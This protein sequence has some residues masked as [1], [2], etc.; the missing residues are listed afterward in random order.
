MLP[1][2]YHFIY[3]ESVAKMKSRS[4]SNIIGGIAL[5]GMYLANLP[6]CAPMPNAPPPIEIIR[7][8]Q[9]RIF[10]VNGFTYTLQLQRVYRTPEGYSAADVLANGRLEQIVDGRRFRL[11]GG[12]FHPDSQA[13]SEV[14]FLDVLE[15]EGAGTPENAADDGIDVV[16]FE[17]S[18]YHN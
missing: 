10:T 18:K 8:G 11:V 6:G 4:L 15:V 17:Q 2:F 13:L 7:L 12:E 16:V 1:H 5:S 9:E 3:R 14:S